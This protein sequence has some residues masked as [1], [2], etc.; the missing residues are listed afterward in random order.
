MKVKVIPFEPWHLKLFD[1]GEFYARPE[2]DA[3]TR[4]YL[5]RQ[6]QGMTLLIG[7]EIA[8]IMGVAPIWDGLGEVTM[9]PSPL[10]YRHL[11]VVLRQA[12]T[13]ID[14]AFNVL[15]LRRLQ[16][17]SLVDHPKHA[18]FLK[19]LGFTHEGTLRGYGPNGEDFHIHAIV[20][21]HHG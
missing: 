21:K 20:R 14:T 4:S 9:V 5:Y 6:I 1:E 2:L 15:G 11:K 12:P 7:G 16:A 18:R 10:L 8:G 19:A 3:E 13:W 17:L